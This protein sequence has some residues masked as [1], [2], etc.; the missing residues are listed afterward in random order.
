MN[1]DNPLRQINFSQLD[2]IF[3]AAREGGWVGFA[4]HDE[5]ARGPEKNIRTWGQ[6]G[7]TG[8]WADKPIHV[9][10]LNLRYHM[11]E[12]I[13]N[14]LLKG[15]DKW[16]ENAR[17]YANEPLANG[18]NYLASRRCM[19]EVAKDPYAITIS[20]I[21]WLTPQIKCLA[22]SEKDGGPYVP[23]TI[24]TCQDGSYPLADQSYL[25]LNRKPGTPVDPKL[26]EFLRYVLSREG[27]AAIMHDGKFLPL[28]AEV[29]LAQ[30]KKLE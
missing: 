3:G 2:G 30:L 13:S 8:E 28:P 29:V 9:H 11:S 27:Q 21:A 24:E 6:L 16:N 20:T 1:K 12:T 25:Y 4:W 15:S 7:L 14:R 23:L 18:D 19:D 10:W 26:K 22:V 5:F 17:L